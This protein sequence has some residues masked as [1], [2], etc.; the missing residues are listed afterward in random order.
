MNEKT[1][2]EE[3][4]VAEIRNDF[5]RRAAERRAFESQWQLNC[6]FV[7]GNQYVYACGDGNIAADESD[8]FWQERQCFNHVAPIVETRLAKLQRV[9]PKMSVR[10]AS[11]DEDDRLSAKAAGK[12]LA[13]AYNALEMDEIVS[14]ATVWSEICGC[15]FYKVEWNASGGKKVGKRGKTSL[16]EGDVRVTVCP[17]FEIYPDRLSRAT[18]AECESIVHARAVPVEEIRQAYGV[19]VTAERTDLVGDAEK[20]LSGGLDGRNTSPLFSRSQ[21]NDCCLLI[22]R[23]T[24]PTKD[25]EQGEYAA[26]A[27]GKLLYLGGLPYACGND[28]APDLPFIKQD[29]IARAGC[30]YGTSTVDR[31][32]PIQRAFN[33]V[34]N[35][36]HE[37]MNR[38]AMGVLAVEDGSV[39]TDNLESE[40]LSPGKILVYRQGSTP[41]TLLDPGRVPTDFGNEEDRLLNE[42]ISVTGVSEIM[43]SSAVPSG[44]TSGVA[45][46]LLI[47]QDDT[48]LSVTAQEVRNAVRGVAKM[49]LRLY[50]QFARRPRLIR[51]VG[52]EGDVELLR[53]TASDISC[54]DVVFETENELTGTPAQRQ[55]ML[56]DLLDKG[57][58]ADEDGKLSNGMRNRVLDAVGYG[59]WENTR[60]VSAL[61]VARARRE[62]LRCNE[63]DL[64]VDEIDDDDLHESEHIRFMLSSEF[65]RMC[66]GTAGLH[67]KM[68]EHVRAHKRQRK[69]KEEAENGKGAGE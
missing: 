64:T 42:F 54:D 57:L 67:E 65:A 18:V 60:E 39:D 52:E 41:P 7:A 19:T 40:G 49:I 53:F 38:I 10:P 68:L 20:Y 5:E 23:Y 45:L 21:A 51:F 25:N 58:L 2:F 44:M 8:Y 48:R 16:Y 9:R 35:R 31:C 61:Q 46:Q 56:F 15:V 6:N 50:R 13:S 47:E 28:G 12:I 62:N 17:P 59:T 32:I 27:G 22:E 11:S 3:E 14:R 55:S 34:K 43:R 26:V 36:K 33:A 37:F 24:R 63:R 30:F 1:V 69:M 29:S 66:N 4:K